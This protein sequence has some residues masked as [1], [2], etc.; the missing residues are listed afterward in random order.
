MAKTRRAS[1]LV[2]SLSLSDK[3]ESIGAYDGEAEVNKDD[4]ALRAD[5]PEGLEKVEEADELEG[6]QS[7]QRIQI[8]ASIFRLLTS[9][10]RHRWWWGAAGWERRPHSQQWASQRGAVPCPWSTREE[11][12]ANKPFRPDYAHADI[13]IRGG[14]GGGVAAPRCSHMR[15][16]AKPRGGSCYLEKQTAPCRQT[17][18]WHNQA[19]AEAR[20]PQGE[21]VRKMERQTK[22]TVRG[23][24]LLRWALDSSNEARGTWRGIIHFPGEVKGAAVFSH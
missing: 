6:D 22:Q 17:V 8:Q 24:V 16:S 20:W 4:G 19:M 5:V 7:T 23:T 18:E 12:R 10:R 11:T 3:N 15:T 21:H 2:A 1:H 14:W 13:H 9:T